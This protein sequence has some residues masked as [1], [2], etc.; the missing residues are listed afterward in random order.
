MMRRPPRSTL[1]PYTTLFRSSVT[2]SPEEER[3]VMATANALKR[4]GFKLTYPFYPSD[5][6]KAA[7]DFIVKLT[8]SSTYRGSGWNFL[9][10]WPGF[11]IWT[12]AWHGYNYG[13]LF[14]FDADITNTKTNNS[15]P[16]ISAPVHL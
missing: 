4:D 11:L 2:S 1:F 12:P 16:R 13:A 3:L 9:I 5:E 15:L 7:V 14:G 10:N 8:T 6:N